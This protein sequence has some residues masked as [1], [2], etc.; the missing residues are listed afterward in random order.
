MNSLNADSTLV[1]Q[2]PFP[3]NIVSFANSI[4]L[5]TSRA[6]HELLLWSVQ[7]DHDCEV[8]DRIRALAE[9]GID[10]DYLYLLARRH[11]VLPLLYFQL[12]QTAGD[13]VAADHLQR[14]QKYY[15][16]NSARNVLLTAELTR[17]IKL[18]GAV[19][20]E[21]ISYKGP[22]LALYAYGDVGLRRFVDLDIM[23][24]KEDVTRAI[25]LLVSEG[26]EFSKPVTASQRE[27][28][29]RTQ[30]NVQFRR[31]KRQLIVELHWEVASHLFA[32]SVQAEE[33]WRDLVT[34]KLNGTAVKTLAAED[35]VFSLCVHGSRHLW[36]RLQWICDVGW[37]VKRYQLQWPLL[38][39]RAKST[40]TERMFL[41]G[42]HLCARLLNVP[43]PDLITKEVEK[44]PQL[45]Y[46]AKE[47]IEALFNGVE[48]KPATAIQIFK[49]NLH[50]RKSWS[51]RARYFRHMLEPTDRDLDAIAL[52]RHFSF[53]YYLM[54][55]FRLLFNSRRDSGC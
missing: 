2:T 36:E 46:L 28:L 48:H 7:P 40:S 10:W 33:L 37:I 8:V 20:V 15:L 19:G 34:I 14:L 5:A 9:G 42:L 53:G 25:D 17:L 22:S 24:R 45:E 38:L 1:G 47:V 31:Y 13:L 18:L 3:V 32:S 4:S 30:H 16:E 23:V 12:Q 54:R 51:S 21:A 43:L 35:L 49:Y 29:L 6:E 26:Y 55:P 41:L 50:V 27:V 39:E 44:D 52:P 11:S